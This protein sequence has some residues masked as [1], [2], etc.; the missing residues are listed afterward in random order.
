MRKGA[1]GELP[2]HRQV[3]KILLTCQKVQMFQV[4]ILRLKEYDMGKYRKRQN[5]RK[6]MTQSYRA[7]KMAA[8][9]I[10]GI[11]EFRI[12]NVFLFIREK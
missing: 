7:C 5:I 6:D 9:C 11:A 1:A 4:D 2:L 8:S 10:T 12:S 3:H